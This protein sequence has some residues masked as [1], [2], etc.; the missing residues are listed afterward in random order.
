MVED[1]QTMEEIQP[2]MIDIKTMGKDAVRVKNILQEVSTT[3]R[4]PKPPAE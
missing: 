3:N 1:K 4:G 2:K